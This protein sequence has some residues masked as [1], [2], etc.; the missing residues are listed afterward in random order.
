[1]IFVPCSVEG[2]GLGTHTRDSEVLSSDSLCG[3][4]NV[5]HSHSVSRGSCRELRVTAKALVEGTP[6]GGG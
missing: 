2:K 6:L 1:M 3:G 5:T 4:A